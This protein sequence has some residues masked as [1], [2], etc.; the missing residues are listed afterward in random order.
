MTYIKGEIIMALIV[1]V[2]EMRDTNKFSEKCKNSNEPIF[3]TKNGYGD[4]VCMSIQLYEE[5][6]GK[7]DVQ[8]KLYEGIKQLN[9]GK[10]IDGEDFINTLTEKYGK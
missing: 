4:L 9:E 5:M 7:T 3:V 10:V 8:R 2:T 6:I 1:P